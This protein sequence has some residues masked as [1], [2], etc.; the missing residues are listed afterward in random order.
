LPGTASSTTPPHF[1]TISDVFYSFHQF[2][3]LPGLSEIPQEDIQYLNL[4]GCFRVPSGGTVDEFVRKYFL[5][6]HPCLPIINEAE[7]WRMYYHQEP[8][9][10][11]EGGLSLFTFQAMLFAA[12]AVYSLIL[13]YL[14]RKMDANFV[15]V[16]L[17]KSN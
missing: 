3:K 4:K 12:S 2:L 1:G 11:E 7:F 15:A 14:V 10:V 5:Y 17:I 6:V 8:A 9:G 13:F 16:R